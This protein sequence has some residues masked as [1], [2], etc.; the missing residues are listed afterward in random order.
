MRNLSWRPSGAAFRACRPGDWFFFRLK[1]P[2][3]AIAGFGRFEPI[4]NSGHGHQVAR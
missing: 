3:Y 4:A 2:H 1:K